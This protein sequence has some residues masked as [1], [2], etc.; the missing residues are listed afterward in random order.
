MEH[1]NRIAKLSDIDHSPLT[2]NVNTDFVHT[3]ADDLNWFPVAWFESVLNRTE[4]EA[5]CPARFIWEIS[6]IVQTRSYEI[7]RLHGHGNII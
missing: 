5:C 4:L 2:Q 1:L 6:Q 3:W 7:Q